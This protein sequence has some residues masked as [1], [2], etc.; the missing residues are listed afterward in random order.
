MVVAVQQRQPV[1][2]AKMEAQQ[3][4]GGSPPGPLT[5]GPISDAWPVV[6]LGLV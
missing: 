3:Q 4:V 5:L 2:A 6:L 1:T